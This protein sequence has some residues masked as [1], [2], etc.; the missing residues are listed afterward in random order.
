MKSAVFGFIPLLIGGKGRRLM[1]AV[2]ML[3]YFTAMA[4]TTGSCVGADDDHS[5]IPLL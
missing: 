1:R 3:I 2:R 5:F 4:F